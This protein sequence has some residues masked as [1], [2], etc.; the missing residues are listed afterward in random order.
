MP[1]IDASALLEL[2]LQTPKAAQVTAAISGGDVAAPELID[3]E[4]L[5]AL[6]RLVRGNHVA[7]ADATAAARL[8]TRVAVTRV[9]HPL[10]ASRVWQ[11]RD[12]VR[13]ADGFYV[14]C[15]ERRKTP[16]VTADARLA[17]APLP[18]VSILLVR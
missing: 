7:E 16:L 2:L 13:V 3:V 10:L 5:S 11:L 14:A 12:R 17:R 1:T 9:S 4:V 15:A 8:L 18:G 6:A